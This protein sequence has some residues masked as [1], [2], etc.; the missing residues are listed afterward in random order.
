MDTSVWSLA[1][2][3]ERPVDEDWVRELTELIQEQR[4]VMIGPVRQ[5]LLSGIR[6]PVQFRTLR[7]HLHAFPDLPLAT[8]DFEYAAEL[9][10]LCRG[11]GVQGSNTDFLIVAVAVQHNLAILTTDKDFLLFAQHMPLRLLKP[12][13]QMD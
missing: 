6:D 4:V 11:K 12:R 13:A 3:R 2:R 10:N 9:F 8:A 7:E 5:E 1:L